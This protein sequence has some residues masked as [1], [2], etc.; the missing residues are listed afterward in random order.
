MSLEKKLKQLCKDVGDIQIESIDLEGMNVYVLVPYETAATSIELE[1]SNDDEI[2][3]SFKEGVNGKLNE[4]IDHL[5][6]CKLY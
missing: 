5:D 3:E 2:I 6:E 4:M 1:G